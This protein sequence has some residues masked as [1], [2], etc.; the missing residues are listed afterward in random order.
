MFYQL[1]PTTLVG[2]E[3][4]QQ[5]RIQILIGLKD[6]L[7]RGVGREIFL[8]IIIIIRSQHS[9]YRSRKILQAVDCEQSLIFL[10]KVAARE[11]QARER[12]SRDER[13]RKPEKK[14]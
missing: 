6:K 7:R 5:M 4:G 8:W 11:T 10:C 1:L 3:W 2:N 9:R 12:R 13:G 14:K